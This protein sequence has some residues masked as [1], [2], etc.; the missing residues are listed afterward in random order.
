MITKKERQKI[1]ERIRRNSLCECMHRKDKHSVL[2]TCLAKNKDDWVYC[3]CN[4]FR[5]LE[6]PN[7]NLNSFAK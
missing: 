2:G 6:N 3:R 4:R 1:I 5:K 7:K